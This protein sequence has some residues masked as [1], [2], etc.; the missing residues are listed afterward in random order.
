VGYSGGPDSTA[1]LAALVRMGAAGLRAIHVDHGIRPAAERAR[2]L[3]LVR[4]TCRRLGV[5][6]T[7][8]T[9]RP[10]AIGA[11]AAL[12]GEGTEAAARRYRYAAFRRCAERFGAAAIYLGHTRDDQLETLLMRL[13][14]GAGTA[15]L[16]G[17][18]PLSGL[19]RRPFLALAKADL[20][21]WL[22]AE[23]LA[24]S[25]DST[26]AQGTYARNRLRNDVLPAITSA[27]PDWDKGLLA[28]ARKAALD[29]EALDSWAARVGFRED[30][31]GRLTAD[32]SLLHEPAA[33]RQRA[34]LRAAAS[35]GRGERLSSRL[36]EAAFRA[37]S[38]GEGRYRGGGLALERRGSVL[39][40]G[41]A[42]D[43]PRACGYF[44]V[45]D[46]PGPGAFSAAIGHLRVSAA[47]RQDGGPGIRK[48]AF[49]FPLIVRSRRPGDA[50]P[51]RGGRKLLDVLF[52]EWGVARDDRDRIPVLEDRQGILAVLAARWGGRDR[53][54]P[55]EGGD[56]APRLA[57]QVKGAK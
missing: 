56:D 44:V 3:S 55:S 16:R 45:I 22:G 6:L 8:A 11:L 17:I 49:S 52:S 14:S 54:R 28:C 50:L 4:L 29:E 37:V 48:G 47:W 51:I 43:F 57:I 24:H 10:G 42:L 2:E 39:T 9:V 30:G 33:I 20:L 53:Y 27:F 21:G 25:T 18:P 41:P 31:A 13:L 32:A 15:G 7:V 5:P 38:G 40:L 19:V 34:F 1:L 23:G 35:F 36:A 12:Q 46:D 26:N